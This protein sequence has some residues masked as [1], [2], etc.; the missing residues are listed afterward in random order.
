MKIDA[1]TSDGVIADTFGSDYRGNMCDYLKQYCAEVE[2]LAQACS[3][4]DKLR[5]H[6]DKT[7][8]EPSR[9]TDRGHGEWS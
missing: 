9:V 6:C 7:Q 3:M 8:N 4:L 5:K 1:A 2:T